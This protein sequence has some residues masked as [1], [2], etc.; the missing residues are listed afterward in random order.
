MNHKHLFAIFAA[1]AFCSSCN[2][3]IYAPALYHHDI[4]YQPKPAS[5]DAVKS[6]NYLSGGVNLYTDETGIDLVSAGQ[7]NFSQGYAFKGS[8]IAYGAFGEFGDYQSGVSHNAPYNFTDKFFGAFGARVSGDLFT[9]YGQ[10]DFRFIGFEAAYSHEFGAYTD[11][12]RFLSQSTSYHIDTRTELYTVGLTSEIIFHNRKTT[13]IEHGIRLFIGT[14]LGPDPYANSDYYSVTALPK[15]FSRLFPKAS[16]F[17]N[18]RRF[19]GVL[20]AG[21]EITVRAGY[22]F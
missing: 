13:N 3:N 19:F 21:S 22:K 4:A 9:S 8:N 14:T 1:F 12:R 20:D 10:T 17:L 15:P 6:A 11:F 5:F 7:V 18:V 16:Y 2:K